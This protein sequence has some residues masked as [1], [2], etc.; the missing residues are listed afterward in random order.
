MEPAI[1]FWPTRKTGREEAARTISNPMGVDGRK[2]NP[3]HG[4]SVIYVRFPVRCY[5]LDTTSILNWIKAAQN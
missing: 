3:G 5:A 1:S 2:S 4:L